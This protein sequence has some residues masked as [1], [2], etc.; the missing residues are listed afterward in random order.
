MSAITAR[1]MAEPA[2]R[3]GARRSW[4]LVI[5]LVLVGVIIVT[6]S[7]SLF[8]L[9]Y[10]TGDISGTRLEQ[11]NPAHWLGTDELGHDLLTQIMIGARIAL[12]VG[13][14]AVLTSA[15]LGAPLLPSCE[16]S[17]HGNH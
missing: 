1:G 7:V 9:P 10:S 2:V 16:I 5:G 13:I 17:Q 8:W 12:V 14:G 4:T 3:R 15:I 11:P 6:A